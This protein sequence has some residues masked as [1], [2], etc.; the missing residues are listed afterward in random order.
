MAEPAAAP[1]PMTARTPRQPYRAPTKDEI[2]A[3]LRADMIAERAWSL[4]L[5]EYI[6]DVL[7]AEVPDEDQ[8]VPAWEAQDFRAYWE[9]QARLSLGDDDAERHPHNEGEPVPVMG[10]TLAP[11]PSA[12]PLL[13]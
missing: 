3:Q 6:D 1:Q 4:R 9:K 10:D 12:A 11:A 8:P 13:A 2:I 5:V 7:C